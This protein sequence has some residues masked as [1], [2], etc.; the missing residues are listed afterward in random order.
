MWTDEKIEA[1]VH[2]YSTRYTGCIPN[3]AAISLLKEMRRDHWERME[4]I[5][6]RLDGVIEHISDIA[7]W[8]TVVERGEGS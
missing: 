2:G 7:S 5:R 1:E 6:R 4:A 3:E 8:E